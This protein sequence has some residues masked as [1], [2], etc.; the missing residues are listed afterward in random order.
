MAACELQC[1][2]VVMW[3][4]GS[5]DERGCAML[6][7]ERDGASYGG[8]RVQVSHFR[9]WVVMGGAGWSLGGAVREGGSTPV[10]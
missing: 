9:M 2:L 8:R 6:P 1:E 5:L 4:G 10:R 3:R 7:E